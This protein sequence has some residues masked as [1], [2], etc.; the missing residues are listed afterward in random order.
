MEPMSR[1]RRD[2]NGDPLR[3][4]FPGGL[5]ARAMEVSDADEIASAIAA[6]GL[7]SPL[8][9]MVL[10]GGAGGLDES[11]IERLRPIF[12]AGIVPVLERFGAVAVDGG[13]LSGVMRILG[14]TR[15]ALGATFPLV[16][17]VAAGTVQL[18]GRPERQDVDAVLEPHHTHFLV[19]PGEQWGA[20]S[21]W[22]ANTA[23]VVA[24]TASSVTVLING[25]QIAYLDVERSVE[26]ARRVIVLAG[27]GRTADALASALAGSGNDGRAQALAA[28]G[29]VRSVPMDEAASFADELAAILSEQPTTA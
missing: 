26:A 1:G 4:D 13:T 27:S 16:G 29:L 18:P 22:I 5:T 19:V 21:P 20:E 15:S 12:V 7:Q 3:L 6:L 9:T 25:G 23:T 24:G 28:S 14:E 2:H 8:P 10:V 17:V 11:D